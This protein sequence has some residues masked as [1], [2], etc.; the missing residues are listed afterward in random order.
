MVDDSP[1]Q[2]A[3]DEDR[4]RWTEHAESVRA[5][6]ARFLMGWS[7]V[8][9][10]VWGAAD[11]VTMGDIPGAVDAFRRMRLCVLVCGVLALLVLRGQ[12]RLVGARLA[13]CIGIWML[14]LG[15][16]AASLSMLGDLSTPWFHC[17]YPIVIAT[18][19][20]P[21][22]LRGRA[23]F[24]SLLAASLVLG[25]VL[26]RP[27]AVH[28]PFFPMSL[29]YMTFTVGVAVAFGHR[30]F[31][32]TREN[33]AQRLVVERS[34]AALA[35]QREALR[36]EVDLRTTELRV[37][38]DHL[39]RGGEEERRRIAR[40]LHDELGQSVSALRLSLATTQRRFHRDPASIR[41]NLGDLDE[42]VRRVA[43]GTR[44]TIAL[45]RPRVL[46]DHGLPAAAEW[47]VRTV[48]KHS[49][50]ACT[51]RLDGPLPA[52]PGAEGAAGEGGDARE[53]AP[54]DATSVAAFR[55]LQEALTNVVRH[56]QARSVT[57]AL[58]F[59]PDAVALSVVDDGVGV[60]ERPSARGGVGIIGMRERAR[61]LG[62]ELAVEAL[63]GGGTRLACRLPLQPRGAA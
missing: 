17:L 57:V 26:A 36:R 52:P 54:I 10:V 14:E 1:A 25:F 31:L 15:G 12:R 39:E 37:L 8:V 35:G 20:F 63:A 45:L 59:D 27:A 29:G 13:A 3:S 24:A 40:E 42:L 47:L 38:A 60:P 50:L 55:I 32:L 9:N 61:S 51:L 22:E 4:L 58:G 46:D 48:E 11:R 21:F 19:V 5:T 16:L 43:D 30:F 6:F 23:L 28:T 33:F 2:L 44:D 62:G 49:G 34:A 18:C 41:A 56:A 7:L 53:L